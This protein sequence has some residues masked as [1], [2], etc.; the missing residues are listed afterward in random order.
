M[1]QEIGWSPRT[2]FFEPVR[3][4]IVNEL[5]TCI[6]QRELRVPCCEP[7]PAGGEGAAGGGADGGRLEALLRAHE[8]AVAQQRV[9]PDAIQLVETFAPLLSEVRKR[10]GRRARVVELSTWTLG[11][12]GPEE[13]GPWAAV[14]SVPEDLRQIAGGVEE[15]MIESTR[16]EDLPAWLSE[17]KNM[18]SLAVYADCND[19]NETNSE[20]TTVPAS[21]GQLQGLK[22]LRLQSLERL[23][24]LP[25]LGELTG[26]ESLA[27]ERLGLQEVPA[28]TWSLTGLTELSLDGFDSVERF[29]EASMGGLTSL[30]DLQ[31]S[32]FKSLETLPASIGQL[33]RLE[34]LVLQDLRGIQRLPEWLGSLAR[35]QK[36][37]IECNSL[38]DI[39]SSIGKLAALEILEVSSDVLEHLPSSMEALTSLVKLCLVRT[40]SG[41]KAVKTL[42]RFLPSFRLLKELHVSTRGQV[43]NVLALGTSFKAWPPS[44]ALSL[45]C[46]LGLRHCWGPLG[47]PPQAC[48]WNDG[49]ILLHFQNERNKVLA[50]VTGTHKRLGAESAVSW[51]DEHAV[52]M[53]ADAVLGRQKLLNEWRRWEDERTKDADGMHC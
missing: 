11:L 49:E 40:R 4:N 22:E 16:L 34:T 20:L 32:G 53:I 35:L 5:N 2:G 23:S 47:L 45:G 21:I 24:E 14:L 27:L 25:P 39:P 8:E 30:A 6:F 15:L 9:T 19:I 51:L 17:M 37:K 42:A 38:A 52:M 36:L 3:V 1:P 7:E 43:D 33:T 26:L 44:C 18:R 46:E 50:F 10:E 41:G 12:N 13:D 29:P 28:W 48:F 31:L